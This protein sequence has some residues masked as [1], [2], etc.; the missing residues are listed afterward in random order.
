MSPWPNR[1]VLRILSDLQQKQ[2]SMRLGRQ[3]AQPV[4]RRFGPYVTMR[5]RKWRI[6]CQ[7]RRAVN[8]AKTG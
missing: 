1:R 7:S 4:G 2:A 6:P 3:A 8:P 5:R